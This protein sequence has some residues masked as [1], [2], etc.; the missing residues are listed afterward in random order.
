MS[1]RGRVNLPKLRFRWKRVNYYNE[2]E[3][4]AASWLGNL[5]DAHLIP[6]GKVDDRNVL[7]VYPEELEGYTQCHFFAGIG[8]W[9]LALKLAGWPDDVPVWTGSCP[10]QPFSICG[11]KKGRD[12]ER[13]LFPA[14]F[15]LIEKR[16]P[17]VVFGEQVA[18]PDGRR[19]LSGVRADLEGLGYRFA[20]ADLCA[21]G[22]AA[23]HIRQRL[24]WVAD[25]TDSDGWTRVRGAQ[26][27]ARPEG[28][29]GVRSS[30]GSP[31]DRLGVASGP[32]LEE[33]EGGQDGPGA[34][35]D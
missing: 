30:G 3:P 16:R 1:A 20:A 24:Y 28:V 13:H 10:C 7:G 11:K 26:A 17:P 5:V 2:F 35:R 23:P 32:G 21:A 33:R 4:Y 34:V 6:D 31:P 15:G 18:S 22:V 8:G 9:P 12:D 19:W 25:T 14:F 29:G 27:G